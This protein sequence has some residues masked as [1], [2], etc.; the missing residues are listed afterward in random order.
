MGLRLAIELKL[1]GHQVSV[2]E[3]RRE[4]RNAQGEAQIQVP[5][6]W[7]PWF[8]YEQLGGSINQGTHKWMV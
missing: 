6:R 2:F 7:F 3:K 1:G 4:H 8:P 5:K